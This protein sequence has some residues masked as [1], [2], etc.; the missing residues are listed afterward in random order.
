M[1]YASKKIIIA[2]L[3]GTLAESK[4]PMDPEMAGIIARLLRFKHFAVI[5]GGSYN[6]FLTQ[7]VK[8]IPADGADLS[9]LYLFPTCATSMYV[10]N[11]N[12]WQNVYTESL[13]DEKK[14][15]IFEA[16]DKA[17][18]D[19]GFQKPEKIYGELIEDRGTQ[20]T[21][22]ANGQT[23]PLEIKS[24][25][26]PDASKRLKIVE[27]LNKYLPEGTQAKISRGPPR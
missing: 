22:S 24:A 14:K 13:P 1:D 16:F 6:Q 9:H 25:Y 8:S 10:N 11:G 2:D 21:F 3:D 17:L 19:A 18:A 7:F 27:H 23:A 5:S 4:S 26:D 12:E 20:I 15:Q